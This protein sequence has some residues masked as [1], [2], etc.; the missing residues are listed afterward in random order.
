[1]L[2]GKVMKKK[3]WWIGLGTFV[4]GK[5]KYNPSSQF[6]NN[7]QPP[8]LDNK[9]QTEMQKNSRRI[10]SVLSLLEKEEEALEKKDNECHAQEARQ[11]N[12]VRVERE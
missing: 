3:L 2:V 8:R 4:E 1:M 6:K 10:L 5:E 7:R 11:I 9:A 12:S